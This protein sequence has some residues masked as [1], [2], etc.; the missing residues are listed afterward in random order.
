MKNKW[1]KKKFRCLF[2]KQFV[3]SETKFFSVS[4]CPSVDSLNV[5]SVRGLKKKLFE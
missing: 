4:N 2:K 5:K 3:C 1:E